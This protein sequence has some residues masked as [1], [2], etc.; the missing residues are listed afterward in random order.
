MLMPPIYLFSIECLYVKNKSML[1]S[2]EADMKTYGREKAIDIAVMVVKK[3]VRI[4]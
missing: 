1:V 2:R 3:I 4:Y